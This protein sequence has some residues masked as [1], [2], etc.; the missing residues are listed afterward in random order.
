MLFVLFY[1][2]KKCVHPDVDLLGNRTYNNRIP[3]GRTVV[4]DGDRTIAQKD[5]SVWAQI[6]GNPEQSSATYKY[7]L[8]APL[9]NSARRRV[10]WQWTI[11]CGCRSTA[12]YDR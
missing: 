7:Y 5:Y 2:R 12:S 9:W 10:G 1:L 8:H 4:S 3:C 6:P 11:S